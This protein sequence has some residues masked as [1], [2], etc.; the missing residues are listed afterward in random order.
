M[1]VPIKYF[2]SFSHCLQQIMANNLT[3]K[4]H[5]LIQEVT[6][7]H[8]K[9]PS[10]L[11]WIERF[12]SGLNK[13]T[14]SSDTSARAHCLGGLSSCPN[15][16]TET[17]GDTDWISDCWDLTAKSLSLYYLGKWSKS[18][19]AAG[20]WRFYRRSPMSIIYGQPGDYTTSC[21][22]LPDP[23]SYAHTWW[24]N[25]DKEKK[26]FSVTYRNYLR[27]SSWQDVNWLKSISDNNQQ[28]SEH[29]KFSAWPPRLLTDLGNDERQNEVSY[30][31]IFSSFNKLSKVP[32][33]YAVWTK[34]A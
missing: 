2:M 9:F 12:I 10:D 28:F 33:L 26:A 21:Q 13:Q 15:K 7:V 5:C 3:L 22:L 16:S 25:R 20:R 30:T 17:R 32:S 19:Q 34:T 24:I 23:S 6:V 1:T 11:A 31:E 4:K 8:N 14:D 29:S 18:D 27:T